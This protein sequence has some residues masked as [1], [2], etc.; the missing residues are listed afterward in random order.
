[1]INML[2]GG[3]EEEWLEETPCAGL[4]RKFDVRNRPD[5]TF[6]FVGVSYVRAS[7]RTEQYK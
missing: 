6:F 2:S 3:Q 5:N 7:T 1:M 4:L